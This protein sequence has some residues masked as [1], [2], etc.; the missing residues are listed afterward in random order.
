VKK[1]FGCDP[2]LLIMVFFFVEPWL[3]LQ[4]TLKFNN[5][6]GTIP[7]ELSVLFFPTGFYCFMCVY[8]PNI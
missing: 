7:L 8:I 6:T 2:S 3:N 4:I 5:L 1:H